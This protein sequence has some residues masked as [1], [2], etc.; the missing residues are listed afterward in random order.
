MYFPECNECEELYHRVV[1]F[2]KFE[3]YNRWSPYVRYCTING[4][5]VFCVDE[6]DVCIKIGKNGIGRTHVTVKNSFAPFV[7]IKTDS[8][9]ITKI[10]KTIKEFNLHISK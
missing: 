7:S 6:Q 9:I 10:V 8:D 5:G 3:N 2:E 1:L 4:V